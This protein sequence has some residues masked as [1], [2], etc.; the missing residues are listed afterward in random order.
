[1]A[2][3]AAI[4]ALYAR[5]DAA[6]G[7]GDVDAIASLAL[8]EARIMI[9]G[10]CSSGRRPGSVMDEVRKGMK[11][12][13]ESTVTAIRIEGDTARVFVN[14]LATRTHAATVRSVASPTATPGSGPSRDGD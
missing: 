4:R 8:P 1:M 13:S 6:Y 5:V 10:R 3:R 11:F 7:A 14:N 2:D 12:R 9:G